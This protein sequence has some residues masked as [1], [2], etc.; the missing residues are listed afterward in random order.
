MTA[1]ACNQS[2]RRDRR[3]CLI[4]TIKPQN[5]SQMA[6]CFT[7]FFSRG[8]IVCLKIGFHHLTLASLKFATQTSLGSNSQCCVPPFS[9]KPLHSLF[10][11]PLRS[12]LQTNKLKRALKRYLLSIFYLLGKG[13]TLNYYFQ[14]KHFLCFIPILSRYQTCYIP[15]HPGLAHNYE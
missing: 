10:C 9:A 5:I 11:K 3:I 2:A 1:H 7:S 15:H 4:S 13:S 14:P 12:D 8:L 6:E